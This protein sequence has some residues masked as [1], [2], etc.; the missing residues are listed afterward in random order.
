MRKQSCIIERLRPRSETLTKG[1]K[2]NSK[3]V[4]AAVVAT[5]CLATI[6]AAAGTAT[7]GGPPSFAAGPAF[8]FVPSRNA[9]HANR[10]NG[11]GHVSLLAWYGGP[12][13][14]STTVVPIYWG[15]KW[16]TSFVG[17]K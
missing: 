11:R 3:S 1:A 10:A 16:N 13:M 15:S 14:H 17:D 9:N 5:V 12:V 8:G 4:L 7:A 2:M 6:V